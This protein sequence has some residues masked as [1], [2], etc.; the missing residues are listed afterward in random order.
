MCDS[1]MEESKTMNKRILAMPLIAAMLLA[2]C[3]GCGS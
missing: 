1:K 2:V 3:V